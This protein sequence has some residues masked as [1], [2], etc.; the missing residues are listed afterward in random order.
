[1]RVALY[2]RV[3]KDDGS[4]TTE[5]Q[6]LELRRFAESQGWPIWKEYTDRESGAKS[7]REQFQAMLKDASRRKF[8]VLLVWA[9]DRLTRAG[10][11]ETLGYLKTL[12][13]YGVRFRSYTE[14]FLDTTGPVRD[15]LI[16]IAGWLGQQER[17]KLIERTRAG[18]ARARLQGKVIG[19]P[20]V[21]VD[22]S[23]IALLRASGQSW[24][25]IREA[26]GV[27]QG[28]ARR[29]VASLAKNVS[30]FVPVTH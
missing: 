21:S 3:S 23:Q 30:E 5:N 18:I 9:S 20:K 28:S 22:A 13:S 10:A 8:D 4:Q 16:A 11:Y 26:T 2:C 27:S 17:A 15:L 7:D 25:Q 6:L 24:A 19:R 29:A 12:D 14:S 1:M